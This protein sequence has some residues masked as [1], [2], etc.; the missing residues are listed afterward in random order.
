MRFVFVVFICLA[1]P[2]SNGDS[3]A[4][5]REVDTRT[6]FEVLQEKGRRSF[7]DFS[8]KEG[9]SFEKMQWECYCV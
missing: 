3:L 8:L 1:F 4:N 6:L 7:K 5:I 9:H 2:R